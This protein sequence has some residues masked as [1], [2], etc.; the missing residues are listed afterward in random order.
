MITSDSSGER[1]LT[2]RQAEMLRIIR[3]QVR[4]Q[5]VAPTTRE[6]GKLM[7][8]RS[9]NGTTEH[10]AELEKKGF[11]RRTRR[12]AV[13]VATPGACAACGAPLAPEAAS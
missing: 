2:P 1:R 12:G 3:R 11:I 7:G 8:V 10:L 9:S 5:G 6:L 13:L 4:E